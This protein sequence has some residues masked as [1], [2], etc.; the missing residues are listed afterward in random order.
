M[1]NNLIDSD[2]WII[3]SGS[4]AFEYY[5]VL[6]D[7]K[8]SFIVIG[9]SS[10][11]TEEFKKKSEFQN[12]YAGGLDAF[13]DLS[14]SIPKFAINCVNVENLKSTT[15]TLIDLGIKN[16]LVEKPGG[17]DKNEINFLVEKSRNKST[18]IYIAYNRRF[19]SSTLK[20]LEFI[21]ET[22]KITSF[23]F[24]FTEWSHQIKDLSTPNIVKNHWLLA[25]S[26]HVIDLAFYLGGDPVV[27]STLKSG[28]LDWHPNGSIFVGAGK[29]ITNA[30]F[31]YHANWQAPGRWSL[32]LLTEKYRLIFKPFEQ[33]HIQKIGSISI[34][35]V[36][37]DDS[38]D[39]N[40][41]PG[42]F[43]Q[44]RCFLF[45]MDKSKLLTIYDH[46]KNI[47]NIYDKIL[48]PK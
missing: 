5:K 16:I 36:E 43:L 34:E 8:L 45:D 14:F 18:N 1:S 24:E 4:M 15:E 21:K 20:A 26:S 30:L 13:K 17:L 19:F 42:L 6:I 22:G 32:E 41:K 11:S 10:K 27:I 31:T 47:E 39:K 28:H 37:I 9:R 25:N 23:H 29:T 40:F 38:L 48:Y 44:T 12:V 46:L 3:G 7:L 33:L 2:L 35:K